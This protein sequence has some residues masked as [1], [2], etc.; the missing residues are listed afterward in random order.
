MIGLFRDNWRLNRSFKELVTALRHDI[1]CLLARFAA[2]SYTEC[3][4]SL[5]DIEPGSKIYGRFPIPP[6]FNFAPVQTL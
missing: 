5:E 4:I 3:V 6:F 2:T 1:I